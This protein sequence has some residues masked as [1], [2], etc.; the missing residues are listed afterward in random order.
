MFALLA[1]LGVVAVIIFV[2]T[3]PRG[4]G[5]ELKFVRERSETEA[6]FLLTN[7]SHTPFAYNLLQ[8]QQMDPMGE[9]GGGRVSVIYTN[10]TLRP[11][12]GVVVVLN[13]ERCCPFR[14]IV[15]TFKKVTFVTRARIKLLQWGMPLEEPS[16]YEERVSPAITNALARELRTGLKNPT[17]PPSR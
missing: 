16:M 14:A 5:V 4:A 8:C 9:W 2:V 12:E 10:A 15:V 6:E 7:G 13:H 11:R 17:A 3:R 1:A